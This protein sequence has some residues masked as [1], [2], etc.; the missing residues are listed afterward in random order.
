MISR[1]L[2]KHYIFGFLVL[3]GAA[4]LILVQA[5]GAGSPML[6][7]AL[8]LLLGAFLI[9]VFFDLLRLGL[10]DEKNS[11]RS[12][13]MERPL[14]NPRGKKEQLTMIYPLHPRFIAIFFDHED[15]NPYESQV[16]SIQALRYE[17]GYFTDSLFLPIRPAE[18][19]TR[20]RLLSPE[21]AAKLLTTYTRGFPLVVHARDYGAVW[22][23]EQSN[24]LL[25]TDSIDTL[26]IARLIYPKLTEYGIEDINDWLRFEV[27]ESDPVYGAKITAA[28]YLDY[29]RLH[30]YDTTLSRSPFAKGADLAPVYPEDVTTLAALE[31]AS[32]GAETDPLPVTAEPLMEQAGEGPEEPAE[33]AA[34]PESRYIGP[35]TPID[36]E[37]FEIPE[38]GHLVPRENE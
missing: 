20:S 25:L 5:I 26:E 34:L 24:S 8:R 17:Y 18:D 3:L 23:R 15:D 1:L 14:F 19:R 22:L 16:F 4:G 35:F 11:Y 30:D 12:M 37:G 38:R 31:T 33:P 10:V 13:L 7:M 28:V 2:T 27:D 9:L 29:L 6:F 32:E 36:E 21:D